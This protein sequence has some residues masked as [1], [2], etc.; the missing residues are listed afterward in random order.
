MEQYADFRTPSDFARQYLFYTD[1][2]GVVNK[3]KLHIDRQS[4][5]NNVFMYVIEGSI[6]VEQNGFHHLGSGD[7]VVMRLSEAHRYYATA[8]VVT[9]VIWMHFADIN[10]PEL[11]DYIEGKA[12]LPYV[13]SVPEVRAAIEGCHN[14]SK[15]NADDRESTYSSQIYQALLCLTQRIRQSEHTRDTTA[16]EA[17]VNKV[18]AY[19][20]AHIHEKPE[21]D[22]FAEACGF[23]KYHFIRLFKQYLGETPI[24]YYYRC[25]V[26]HSK[27]RL[28]YTGESITS[29]AISLGFDSQSHYS[30]TFSKVVGKSPRTYIK[31]NWR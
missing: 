3:S 13:D 20:D 21:L 18:R 8:D 1:G 5:R 11:L 23:S 10:H 31:E 7:M 27:G 14:A 28:I 30:R 17:F 15:N 16:E 22:R 19:I 4:F 29:I 24:R 12:G 25:K 9:T 2:M 26:E 6:Y